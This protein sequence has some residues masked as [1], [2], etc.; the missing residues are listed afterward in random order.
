MFTKALTVGGD[1]SARFVFKNEKERTD[2]VENELPKL[3]NRYGNISIVKEYDLPG[4]QIGDICR[5]IGEGTDE[6]VI[7]EV[8]KYSPYRYGFRL[9][10]GFC[11]EV[12][13]CY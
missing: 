9:D 6:F 12:A 10:S 3:R 4:Y 11:E 13:K 5:V 7:E 1:L 2:W 8:F